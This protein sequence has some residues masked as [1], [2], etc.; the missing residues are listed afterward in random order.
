M[1]HSDQL[2]D[3]KIFN[4]H[5]LTNGTGDIFFDYSALHPLNLLQVEAFHLSNFWKL[6]L[7]IVGWQIC[8]PIVSLIE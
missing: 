8:L 3:Q 1:S 5:W 7:V 6:T 4:L 2:F